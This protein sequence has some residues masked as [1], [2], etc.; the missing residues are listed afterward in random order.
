MVSLGI[1]PQVCLID[2]VDPAPMPVDDLYTN[3]TRG[4][5]QRKFQGKPSYKA[6]QYFHY[7]WVN[8]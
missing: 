5:T 6:V 1:C 2:A 3:R 4:Y 7:C 8:R